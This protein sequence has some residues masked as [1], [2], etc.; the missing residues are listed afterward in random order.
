M[1]QMIPANYRFKR[2]MIRER[3]VCKIGARQ[4]SGRSALLWRSPALTWL[5]EPPLL[6]IWGHHI[7]GWHIRVAVAGAGDGP[8]L[9]MARWSQGLNCQ[10]RES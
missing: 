4:R 10:V 1:Q 3:I 9:P 6:H 7:W 8:G 2:K 5:A